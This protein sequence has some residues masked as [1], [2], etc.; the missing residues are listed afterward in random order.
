VSAVCAEDH[1]ARPQVGAHAGGD[2]FF[3]DVGVTR[4]VNQTPLMR[5]GKLL[6]RLPDDLHRP[7]KVEQRSGRFV[8][9]GCSGAGDFEDTGTAV[10]GGHDRTT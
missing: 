9:S 1:I 6:F 4:A 7:V 2:R 3:A 8:G 10:F 5:A